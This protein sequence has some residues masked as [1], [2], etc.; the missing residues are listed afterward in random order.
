MY[1]R[2]IAKDQSI[3]GVTVRTSTISE[4]C[5]RI[6]YLLSDKTGTLTRNEMS[7]KKLHLGTV[8]FTLESQ[9][10]VKEKLKQEL[11]RRVL[12]STE[13]SEDKSSIDSE[14]KESPPTF[15]GA[16]GRPKREL[17]G[18]L[19]DT[20]LA[21]AICHN[22][23]PVLRNDDDDDEKDSSRSP[24]DNKVTTK[25][26]IKSFQAASPDE[27]AIAEWAAGV[28]LCLTHRDR[29]TVILTLDTNEPLQLQFEILQCFPF[30][31][32]SKR[33]GILV[34]NRHDGQII[35]YQ[36]G[37]DSVMARILQPTDWLGEEVGNMAREG[38]R[39]LAV[40]R[41]TLT[42]SEYEA[43]ATAYA[44]ASLSMDDRSAKCTAVIQ[45]LLEHDLELLAVTGVEDKL[46][47]DV[48]TTLE[49][50]RQAGI[51]IWMLT[52]DKVETAMCIATSS[53]LFARSHRIIQLQLAADP[54]HDK[55]QP[56]RP[57]PGEAAVG[58]ASCRQPQSKGLPFGKAAIKMTVIHA[59]LALT[60]APVLISPEEVLEYLQVRPASTVIVI[61]GQALQ[62]FMAVPLFWRVILELPAVAACRCTPQQKAAIVRGIKK[63]A[64]K[65]SRVA[66]IGDGGN[67]VSM[68]QAAD[69]GFGLEGREGRQAALSSDFSLRQFSHV[70]RLLLWHGRNAYRST[71]KVSQ[72]VMHRGV[73]IAVMQAVFSCITHFAPIALYQGLLAVGYTTVYTMG[74]VF[75]LVFDRDV[76]P[77][78]ALLYPEL[79]RDLTKGR[80]LSYKTFF[81][82]LLVSVY[83]G[84]VVMLLAMIL[85]ERDFLHI[86]AISFTSILL[87][88]LAMVALYINTWHPVMFLA[89]LASL[90]IYAASVVVLREDFDR[91][92]VLTGRFVWKV[93]VMTGVSFA[94]LLV[95]KVVRRIV[96]PPS[97][98]KLVP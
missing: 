30:T 44:Q 94:P 18:R 47:E 64:P 23:T 38:L 19:A 92:F 34:K 82:W 12:K 16:Y 4:E 35:F 97:Y 68:L 28:G 1:A 20:C 57:P 88:E 8:A 83:Q 80:D 31:S 21:L 27:V 75:S 49:A 46:Q 59:S 89:E 81:Q 14:R 90:T 76:T 73:V 51:K 67:D 6:H 74:P 25:Y 10:E 37:A 63:V 65:N 11:V 96:A 33:M 85:F 24:S 77:E 50:L 17:T 36:K 98:T 84:G 2:D 53:R 87:S 54:E 91:S 79:Y 71:C 70:T 29:N 61:D 9:L 13:T 52:G 41:R 48:K 72:F 66:C 40:G 26:G 56:D 5:G 62:V 3:P 69:V 45:D 95:I 15:I 78:V 22:V 7:L 42:H 93:T 60:E 43:F 86:V 39:T 58:P 55:K 32:E